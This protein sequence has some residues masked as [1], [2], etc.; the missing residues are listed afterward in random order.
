MNTDSNNLSKSTTEK[1]S[2]DVDLLALVFVLLRGW[3]IVLF[4][5]LLG[6]IIGVLYSRYENPTYKSDAL[7]Q[8]DTTSQGVSALGSN[9]SDLVS[10]D[11]SPAQTEALLIKSRMILKPVVD[12]LHLDI[13]LNDPSINALDKINSDRTHTQINTPEGVAL[14]TADGQVQIS[15]LNVS[16]AYLDQPFTLV[17]SGTDNNFTL[18]NGFDDFKGQLN[19]ANYFRGTDGII[20]ITVNDLPDNDHPITIAKQSLQNTTDAINGALT[21]TEL[22]DKTGI[23]QLS[24]IGSN[25]QQIT[26]I[27]K[28]IVESYIDKNKS[29][30]SE[31]TTK[32][33]SFMETQIPLLKQKL[34]ASEATFNDFRERSGSI[35]ISQESGLLVAENSQIDSQ[36]NELKL[37]KADL[38]TY[39]TEEHPLVLQINDQLKVLNNRKQSIKSDIAKLPGTQREFLKLSADTTIN[40][41]I[42]L[43]MLKNY[44]QLKIVKAGQIGFARIIDMP[45]STYRTIAPKKQLIVMLSILSGILFGILLVFLKSMLK[46]T[47]KDPDR[48]ESKTGVPVIAT[49]PRSSSLT[50]LGK[51]KKTPNRLLAYID[52][53]SLSYEAIKSLRTHLIFGMPEH[54]KSGQRAKVILISGESPGVGKTFIAANL[55]EVFAQLDHKIL[56]I[57]ADMRMG[58]LH[59][60]FNIEQNFGLADYLSLKN[61]APTTSKSITEYVH[62]TGMDN[63]DFMPRGQHPKQP[64][65]LLASKKF[66][67][68]MSQLSEHYDY[69]VVDSPPILAASDAIIL[70]QYAD[71]LLMVTRYNSSIERQLVYAINQLT[72]DHVRVDGIVMNDVQQGVMDKYSYHYSYAYGN[73]K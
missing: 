35:D 33:L 67:D 50:R 73:N 8:I 66:N 14:K 13:R 47:V 62:A 23:I 2:N 25:Q 44:E 41:E 42:Y 11:V 10:T 52:H 60:M 20:Q 34:E 1:S 7:I 71:K 39:Y 59:K 27:L 56:I 12:L 55:S 3:K 4:F 17:R 6:L 19:K 5:A 57:D 64:T 29:R 49:I 9:I 24:L 18:S 63:I 43:T 30:G 21:V 37:K 69:I 15:Q 70:S 61:S 68:L 58:E 45:I 65:T 28:Q 26:L 72:K 22:N 16:Q 32:T 53:N 31:E 48:L 46:N 40:R 54:G 36:I 38:T 51:N